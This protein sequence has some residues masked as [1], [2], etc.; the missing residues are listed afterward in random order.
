MNTTTMLSALILMGA[1][2]LAA[3]TGVNALLTWS[4]PNPSG[5]VKYAVITRV[6][7]L[8]VTALGN[9]TNATQF[10]TPIL[11][12]SNSFRLRLVGTNDVPSPEVVA[13]V[14]APMAPVG[15]KATIVLQFGTP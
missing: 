4:D 1:N 12:G 8:K 11:A 2:A 5:V 9:V 6:D 10:T 7:G 15:F 3:D 14:F 13:D